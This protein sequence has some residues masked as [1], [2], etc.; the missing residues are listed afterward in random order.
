MT[1]S[2]I[3][4]RYVAFNGRRSGLNAVIAVSEGRSS[5]PR[6]LGAGRRTAC[7]RLRQYGVSHFCRPCEFS[8]C[9]GI[10]CTLTWTSGIRGDASTLPVDCRKGMVLMHDAPCA[11]D[12]AQTDRHPKL[13]P[14]WVSAGTAAHDAVGEAYV[15]AG[16][17]IELLDIERL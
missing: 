16:D 3:H 13:K 15:V 1:A 14:G 7:S 5:D 12:P 17:D 8:A 11:V 2:P 4:S 6:H 9:P 10:R